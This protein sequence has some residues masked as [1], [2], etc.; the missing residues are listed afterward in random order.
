M[1]SFTIFYYGKSYLVYV[2]AAIVFG[3]GA[4]MSEMLCG[5]FLIAQMPNNKA[6]AG[7]IAVCGNAF[8]PLFWSNVSLYMLNPNNQD[9][10]ITRV[11]GSFETKYFSFEIVKNLPNLWLVAIVLY[12]IYLVLLTPFLSDQ[13]SKDKKP[14]QMQSKIQ[15]QPDALKA[16]M[17][18]H[19]NQQKAYDRKS[20]KILYSSQFII[21]IVMITF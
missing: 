12:T 19:E 11:E 16:Y 15:E 13:E 1:I 18:Y 9:P 3:T 21:L 6:R 10:A 17:S 4:A 5:L 2:I 8:G 7:G 14:A 20:E